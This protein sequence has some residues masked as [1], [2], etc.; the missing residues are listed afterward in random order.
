MIGIALNTLDNRL[1]M[2]LAAGMSSTA[3][4]QTARELREEIWREVRA[5]H[6]AGTTGET[7]VHAL[8]SAAD[9][10]VR[11]ACDAAA[12]QCGDLETLEESVCV[13]ALGGYG[14]NELSPQ[15]DL[16]LCLL[17]RDP[18]NEIIESANAYLV[19]F[20]WDAGFDSGY[21]FQSIPEAREIALGEPAML[22][23]YVLSRPLWGNGELLA[24][25][26][27]SI[28]GLET[29]AGTLCFEQAMLRR[30]RAT[31]AP[32]HAERFSPEPNLKEQAGGLRDYH[33]ARWMLALAFG[34][35]PLDVLAAR[36]VLPGDAVL[37]LNEGLDFL[38][39]V[40]N[41]MHWW[42]GK[43]HD[44]LTY[45]AQEHVAQAFDYG[46]EPARAVE[47]LMQDYYAAARS[48]RDF[49]RTAAQACHKDTASH[50]T[51]DDTEAADRQVFILQGRIHA[52]A[53]DPHWFTESPPRLMRVFWES[54]RART[55]VS[56]ATLARIAAHRHLVGPEFQ[57]N[58]LVRRFFFA[59]GAHADY[60]G[61]VLRQ[62]AECGL[63]GAYIPEFGAV[64]GMVRHK[65]FHSFPVDE[66]TIR[67]IE[68]LGEIANIEGTV[69]RFLERT[70]EHVQEPNALVLAIL[71]HDLGKA[72][73]GE[74]VE[75]GLKIV[76]T[77]AARMGWPESM[78]ERVMFLVRHHMVMN[79]LSMYRDTDD[80]AVVAAF[81]N[82]M[83][84][85]E[86]LRELVLVSYCD[87]RAVAP[88][89]W[90]DWKGALL[91]KLSL[92]T[93]RILSG[94]DHKL[95]EDYWRSPRVKEIVAALQGL[96]P[97]TDPA[98]IEERV[99]HHLDGYGD[100]Y[101]IAFRSNEIAE[102]VHALEQ[103]G[104]DGLVVRHALHED[105]KMSEV[106]VFSIDRPRL[107][108][109]ITGAFASQ[110]AAVKSAG[111][112]TNGMG[113]VV[114][115]F[116][117][118]DARDA[119]PLTPQQFDAF[120]HTLRKVLLEGGDIQSLVDQSRRRLFAILH[121]PAP[122]AT[123]VQFDD[124]ASPNDTVVDIETGDRTGLLYDIA[125]VFSENGVSVL[126]ARIDTDNLRVRDAFHVQIDGKPLT[127][128]KLR[129][130][131]RQQLHKRL[132]PLAAANM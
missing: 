78:T 93:E 59:I 82:T 1:R 95:G 42:K 57:G 61:K 118:S 130:V 50:T 67:A 45:A 69:G 115:V 58:D 19:P 102:H 36:G 2:S 35:V 72:I 66:H 54:A 48:V 70:L 92:K 117:V 90:N 91:M 11:T 100:R 128:P 37:R 123:R 112:F 98:T 31:L 101:L 15:S 71:F 40:R 97:D 96:E 110:G 30:N 126:S 21:V 20:F 22:T 109:N 24:E 106:R 56:D 76:E 105:G 132:E 33:A 13:C 29:E 63:L 27:A 107:F 116:L 55:P 39:R 87:L 53:T 16:D 131:L 32:E 25:L 86:R 73:E 60:S 111:L 85:D 5:H 46:K 7:V 12:A 3:L 68:S 10:I 125:T 81:A 34:D 18:R 119:R 65:A 6:D 64:Q 124:T 44:T 127:D 121:P 62:M 120:E 75:E 80:P 4:A 108:S 129:E 114:D 103:A 41:E 79:E 77:A 104:S 8:S 28:G 74:H 89:V 23:S 52:G 84:S 49:L 113:D 99:H 43:R 26:K 122:V 47:R 83:R 38:W 94:R 88:G 17:Y 9:I 14:R 51:D